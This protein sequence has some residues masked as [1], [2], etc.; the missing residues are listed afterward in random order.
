M[1]EFNLRILTPDGP[2]FEGMVESVIVR[3]TE[4]DV[5]FLYGHIDYVTTIEYGRVKIRQNGVD[6]YAACMG[7]F[8]SVAD[9][10]VRIV[11]TT[12][13]YADEI[14]VK[15]AETAKKKAQERL[16]KAQSD[17]E[18]RLAEIKLSRALNRLTVAKLKE[19]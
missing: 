11:A 3:S 8:A 18:M 2:A 1:R 10:E 9:G 16:E 4:G 7:G 5:C 15:R 6:R 14:D 13:E 17:K 12:F 19:I